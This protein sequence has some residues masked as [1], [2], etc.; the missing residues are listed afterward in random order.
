MK[1]IDAVVFDMDGVI[2][3]GDKLIPGADK[4]F[5]KLCDKKIPTMIVT[6]ECRYTVGELKEGLSD[7]GIPISSN[8]EFY[9]AGL[10][11]RDYLESKLRRFPEYNYHIGIIGESGL[12]QTINSLSKYKNC[13]LSNDLGDDIKNK[14][15]L[16]IGTVNRIKMT[17]LDMILEWVKYGARIITTCPDAS[18]PSSKGDFNLGMPNHMLHM[19]GFNIKTNSYSTGKPNP[20]HRTKIMERFKITDPK[21]I[22]FVG[23]TMYTD[24]RLA[25]E[26]GF[27]SCLVLSGNT[28]IEALETYTIDPDFVIN[29]ITELDKIFCIN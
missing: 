11:A 20:I 3:I 21:K 15:Y 4:I 25:E 23:D 18:D 1:D 28:K 16:V 26:S 2:R 10:S 9:T 14:L 8:I 24:I 27:K 5:Q 19:T 22:L 6:N 12:Y 17:H 7:L 29:D 13:I